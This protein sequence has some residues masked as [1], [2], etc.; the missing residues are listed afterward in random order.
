MLAL[1]VDPG[2]TKSGMLFYDGTYND[3][4]VMHPRSDISNFELLRFD[5]KHEFK[6][7]VI[8]IEM[9]ASYGMA[10]GAS[11]FETCVWIGRFIQKFG[12]ERVKLIYR[13]DVKKCLCGSM[14]A[15]DS[16][17]RQAIIERFPAAGGGK[18]PQIGTKKQP[19]PLFGISSH[20][21]SAL[22]LGITYF[23]TLKEK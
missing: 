19:G 5:L 9:V 4:S 18:T 6:P 10:V 16:N 12:E 3:L 8:L 22:A 21:W 11:T 2:T 14:Q 23:E 20:C 15:K 7:D 17:I 1:C 13:K